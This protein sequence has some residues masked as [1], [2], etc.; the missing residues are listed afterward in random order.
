M[1]KRTFLTVAVFLT[2]T[3][4]SVAG[5]SISTTATDP[6]N[7]CSVLDKNLSDN[8]FS[9]RQM[10]RLRKEK[11]V[12]G[13]DYCE[14]QAKDCNVHTMEFHGLSLIVLAKKK[15]HEAFPLVATLS[16]PSWSLLG[17]VKVGRP[18]EFLEKHYGA[19]I[20]RDVS[21]VVLMGECTPLTVWHVNGRVTQL[22]LDCQACI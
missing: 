15:T 8:L 17:D 20:P 6:A 14:H 3:T 7:T 9:I 22:K 21:P 19:T 18:L 1:C 16:A 10:E 11:V 5:D 12:G 13:A 4:A 2:S